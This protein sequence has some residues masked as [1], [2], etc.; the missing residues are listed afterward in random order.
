MRLADLL[1]RVLVRSVENIEEDSLDTINI[2]G[3]AQDTRKVKQG[4][5]FVCIKGHTV[6]GHNF[7]K[8]AVAEGAIAIVADR[9]VEIDVPVIYVKDTNKALPQLADA[10]YHHPSEALTLYGV[11]GTNGKTTVTHIIEHILRATQH[12]TGLIGTLYNRIGENTFPTVNT[13]PEAVTL[14]SL[15]ADMQAEKVT[16]C[17]MEV[18]SHALYEGRVWGVDFDVAVFTNLSQDHLDFHGTMDNYFLAKSLLFSQLGSSYAGK[19]KFAIINVDDAYGKQL[20]P[21][22]SATILTYGCE[23]EG[24]IQAKNIEFQ[25]DG[26]HFELLLGDQTY[27]VK[28][29]LLGRFNVYNILAAIGA[30][31]VK[32]IAPEAIVE[33][34]SSFTSVRGRMELVPN[35]QGLTILVDY[36]HTPDGLENV[37]NSLKKIK[38]R[39]IITVV[40]CGGDRD[41]LKRPIMAEVATRLSNH[42]VFTSDNPRTEDP[43][44]ILDDMTAD[45]EAINYEVVADRKKA[46]YK[47]LAKAKE[48]DIILIAGKG[49]E[50]YQIIGTIKYDFDDVKVVKEALAGK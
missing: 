26:T 1:S 5:L 17:V 29:P 22:T 33:A 6:D 49:H 18:S 24:D 11:T 30:T 42:V 19:E 32:G 45:L 2:K 27:E 47:A 44:K 8:Q 38:Q 36:A 4:F 14:Q 40:G 20:L 10:F 12:K 39:K 7:V 35:N 50:T 9:P 13:T 31:F 15:F 16:D 3:V 37:L 41:Q 46:I 25:S 28:V 34:L 43:E 48:Q 23:G 21:L